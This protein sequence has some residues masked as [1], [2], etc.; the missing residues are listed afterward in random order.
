MLC[1]Q[2]AEDACECRLVGAEGV[3]QCIGGDGPHLVPCLVCESYCLVVEGSDLGELDSEV[4]VS[5]IGCFVY[6]DLVDCSADQGAPADSA[7]SCLFVESCEPM[8]IAFEGD[9]A[10]ALEGRFFRWS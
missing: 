5:A 6:L 7:S 1:D 2:R 3:E 10:C 4:L 8:G 9:D